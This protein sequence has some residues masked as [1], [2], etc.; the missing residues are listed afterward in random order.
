MELGKLRSWKWIAWLR[1][2]PVWFYSPRI[3]KHPALLVLSSLPGCQGKGC[4]LPPWKS[5]AVGGPWSHP[6][7][8]SRERKNPS[9]CRI[10]ME[11]Q[12]EPTSE[13][14]E[15]PALLRHHV[16]IC[17][18]RFPFRGICLITVIAKTVNGWW[19]HQYILIEHIELAEQNHSSWPFP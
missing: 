8:G 15:I 16:R 17:L 12:S 4:D 13:T 10:C 11:T 2:L 3:A 19:T 18:E 5:V 1:K 6:H 7:S 9:S 14:C